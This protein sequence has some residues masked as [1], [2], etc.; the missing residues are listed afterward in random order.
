MLT[1]GFY[2]EIELSYDPTIAQE[3]NGRP[4]GIDSLREIQ[5]SKREVLPTLYKGRESFAVEE[6]KDFL[7]RSIGMEPEQLTPRARDMAIPPDLAE[8]IALFRATGHIRREQDE[9]F[10]ELA[11]S[12]VMIGQGVMPE[13]HHPLA[14][15][16]GDDDIRGFLGSLRQAIAGAVATLPSHSDFLRSNRSQHR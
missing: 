11:W 12:Q 6:W 8:R 4:F 13:A 14:R 5:L 2:A 7:I 1:G 16:L 10:T 9:L 3:K 15:L